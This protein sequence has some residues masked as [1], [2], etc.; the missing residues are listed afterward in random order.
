M[1]VS[2]WEIYSYVPHVILHILLSYDIHI[3]CSVYV[4]IIII[5]EVNINEN[6][7]NGQLLKT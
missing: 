7:N 6:V 1:A 4:N 3:C 2:M 5:K